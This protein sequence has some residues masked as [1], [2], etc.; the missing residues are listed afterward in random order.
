[1]VY[2]CRFIHLCFVFICHGKSGVV[3]MAC[4]AVCVFVSVCVFVWLRLCA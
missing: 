2:C 3:F 1:M 4:V